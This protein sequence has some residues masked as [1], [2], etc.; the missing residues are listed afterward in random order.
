MKTPITSD[1]L[2]IINKIA[3]VSL[4][5]EWD[6]PGLQIGDPA[7]QASRIM[8]AL[9]PSAEVIDSAIRSSCQLLVTHHPLIFKPL[10]SIS[11]STSQGAAI[12]AAIRAGLSIICMHT[13]YD[14]ARGGLNDLLATRIG[15]SDCIPLH[16]T[17]VQELL[18][19]VVFVPAEYLE[20][21]RSALF[22]YADSFGNYCDCS[23]TTSGEGTFTPLDGADPFIGTVGQHQKVSEQRLELLLESRNLPRAI[24]ALLAVH[25]YEEPAFDIYPLRNEGEKLGLGRIGQ[26]PEEL[27]LADFAGQ[28]RKTLP[29]AG[30]RYVGDPSA[31]V[32]KVALCSGSG[33]A[34]LRD[35]ARAGADVLVT[36]DVKYHEAREA[37]ELGIALIDAGHFNTEIIMAA[38]I[39]EQIEAALCSA[40]YKNCQVLPCR[41]ETDPFRT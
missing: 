23:F 7:A 36:G 40:G 30:L 31:T 26:L 3:P 21:L 25:P 24:K 13:N 9:D 35:A 12:H 17:T 20:Q 19:L 32:S 39:T 4:A 10:K 2:G 33:A 41:V 5:E 14:I 28:L 16:V 18:K 29:A 11:T 27:S 34:L 37:Q 38:E 22:P 15:L 6:N 8:V 1:V